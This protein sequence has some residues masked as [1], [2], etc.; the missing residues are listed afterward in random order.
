M[1]GVGAV[2]EWPKKGR[3]EGERESFQKWSA[4]VRMPRG[5]GGVVAHVSM[6]EA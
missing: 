1:L 4:E 5:Q 3:R 6:V 2:C